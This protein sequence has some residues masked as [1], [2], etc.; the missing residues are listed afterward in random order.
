MISVIS[1]MLS[2]ELYTGG[3]KACTSSLLG[4]ASKLQRLNVCVHS[5]VI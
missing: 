3:D 5:Q 4:I 1:F 2:G